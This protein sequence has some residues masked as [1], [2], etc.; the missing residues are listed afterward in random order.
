MLIKVTL[1]D[2]ND[3]LN[4]PKT[5]IKVEKILLKEEFQNKEKFSFRD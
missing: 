4:N 2:I 5:I 3:F 1:T